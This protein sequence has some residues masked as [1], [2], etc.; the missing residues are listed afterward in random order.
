LGKPRPPYITAPTIDMDNNFLLSRQPIYRSQV[1]VA[2]YELRAHSRSAASESDDAA[3]TTRVIFNTFTDWGLDQIVGEHPGLIHLNAQSLADGL[4]RPIPKSRVMLGYFADF[5]PTEGPARELSELASAGYRTALSDE[6]CPESLDS[7]ADSAHLIKVDITR[8]QPDELEHRVAELR[9][10][11]AKILAGNVDTYDDLEFCRSLD[12]DF[13]QGTFLSK[14]AA[15][16]KELPVGRRT[17]VLLLSKLQNPEIPVTELEQAISLDV[18][19]SFKLLRYANSAAVALPRSVSSI[20]HAVRLVG[21]DLLRTWSSALLLSTIDDKPRELMTVALVRSR[22]CDL[23]AQSIKSSQRESFSSA[24]LL[25]VLDALLDCPM[26]QVMA[27]LPLTAEIRN[28]ITDRTG[29]IGQALRCVVAYENSDWDE[30]QFY[31]ISAATI[32]D[33]YMEAIAWARQLSNG[34]LN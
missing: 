10:Y 8:Y 28:A 33:H 29:P 12:F 32:R 2:A 21:T 13:Y 11:Q 31:G 14:P 18:T 34:L 7:L 30:V 19:I 25:S 5:A 16:K 22:M 17:I 1:D 6:L 20:G 24:G 27:E 3:A 26:A 23:L 15:A 4:W 9:R